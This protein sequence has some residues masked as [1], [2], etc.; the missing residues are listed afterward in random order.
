[1]G[2]GEEK[3]G[4]QA[5]PPPSI[6]NASM[7]HKNADD[8]VF[9]MKAMESLL[10]SYASEGLL[11]PGP[12]RVLFDEF[13]INPAVQSGSCSADIANPNSK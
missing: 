10:Q 12:A 5:V 13:G 3:L 2:A 7:G 1:M 8:A 4:H 6:K 11:E 9:D